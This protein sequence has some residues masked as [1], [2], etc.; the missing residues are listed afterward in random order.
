MI[1][2]YIKKE[3][4]ENKLIVFDTNVLLNFYYYDEWNLKCLKKFFHD[5]SVYIWEPMHIKREFENARENKI[6]EIIRQFNKLGKFFEKE[7]KSIQDFLKEFNRNRMIDVDFFRKY[8]VDFNCDIQQ[9]YSMQKQFFEKCVERM[10]KYKDKKQD[11]L[12]EIL[13]EN[14]FS[15][16]GESSKFNINKWLSDYE[17]FGNYPGKEDSKKDNNE[18]GD[19]LIWVEMQLRS[20]EVKKDIVFVTGDR[21]NDWCDE[22][23]NC[24][25]FLLDKFKEKTG[26]TF[27]FLSFDELISKIT[28]KQNFD[29]LLNFIQGRYYYEDTIKN[30][31][32]Y[33]N[34]YSSLA[35]KDI[36]T[37]TR[38]G[39]LGYLSEHT[40]QEWRLL[41][42]TREFIDYEFESLICG[43][44]EKYRYALAMPVFTFNRFDHCELLC[45]II[46]KY[47]TPNE[48][49]EKK[50]FEISIEE[51]E[52]WHQIP[53]NNYLESINAFFRNKLGKQE[54]TLNGTYISYVLK[55]IIER[56]DRME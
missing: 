15:K 7:N 28:T 54:N 29:I 9:R 52:V 44:I 3:A 43:G 32:P 56:N 1:E 4:M 24:H 34:E 55:S 17:Q 2:N 23:G 14:V 10:G 38:K 19:F 30:I 11:M 25:D 49:F 22:N 26:K 6:N 51:S 33:R 12:L 21:K 42:M 40:T 18:Y 48:G 20:K 36:V 8:T 27:F 46:V 5:I 50:Y 31:S 37:K 45:K 41:L 53:E 35:I 13:N 39:E 47:I 16:V